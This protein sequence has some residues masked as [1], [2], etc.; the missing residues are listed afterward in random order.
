MKKCTGPIITFANDDRVTI[1]GRILRKTKIDEIP[2]LVNV[3][4]GDM[5]FIG[6]RPEVLEYFDKAATQGLPQ[7]QYHLGI[8]YRDGRGVEKNSDIASY[9]FRKAKANGLIETDHLNESFAIRE[10]NDVHLYVQN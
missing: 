5:R 6:P 8:H 10:P 3:I 9:W 2:Q 7:A 1:F 4:K